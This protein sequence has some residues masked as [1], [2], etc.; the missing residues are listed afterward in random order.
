MFYH[1]GGSGYRATEGK[2]SWWWEAPCR[3]VLCVSQPSNL[4]KA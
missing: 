2:V 1:Y 4:G 3:W